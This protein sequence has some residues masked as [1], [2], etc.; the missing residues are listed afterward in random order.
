MERKYLGPCISVDEATGEVDLVDADDNEWDPI[1]QEMYD[2]A[3]L[4]WAFKL[5]LYA[6]KYY[7]FYLTDEGKRVTELRQQMSAVEARAL[8]R[9]T[10]RRITQLQ[11]LSEDEREPTKD[12]QQSIVDEK[13]AAL[14]I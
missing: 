14:T 5:K 8:V 4:R 13:I 10:M 6:K 9:K 11:I 1:N 2:Q 7:S 3:V 12:S